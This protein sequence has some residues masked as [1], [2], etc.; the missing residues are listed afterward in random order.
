MSASVLEEAIHHGS[1]A[2]LTT[3]LGVET[4]RLCPLFALHSL[5]LRVVCPASSLEE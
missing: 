5:F 1:L 4:V 3:A 2:P